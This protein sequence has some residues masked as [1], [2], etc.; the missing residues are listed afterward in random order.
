MRTP[1][2]ATLLLLFTTASQAQ[3]L[4]R[5]GCRFYHGEKPPKA[6]PLTDG[7]L[8]SIQETIAR[9]DTFDIQHYDIRIDVTDYSGKSITASTRVVFTPRM[10]GQDFIRFDL[11][12]LTVDSVTHSSGPLVFTHDGEYLKVDLPSVQ[13]AVSDT[14]TVHYHGDPYREPN[15]GGFYFESQYIYNLG[16]GLTTI[17]PNFGKVWYPCFDSFVERATY[18]YHVKSAG[19]FRAHCQGDFLG[20]VQLG[21][22]TVVRTYDLTEPIPTYGSAIAVADYRD[23]T[24]LHA[25]AYGTYPITLTSKPGV[26]G[27]FV[28]KMADLPGTIDCLE[29]WYGPYT[30]GR[31]G[32]VLTTDGAL[33]IAQNIAYPDFMPGQSLFNNRGLLA[34]EL[35]HQWWGIRVSPYTHNEMWLKEGPAEYSGHLAEEWL[36]GRDAFVD[37]VKDNHLDILRTAHIVDDGFQVLS[38]IPDEHCY[39]THTYYKG[40]SVMHNLRGYL[41]DTLFR[42]GM[43]HAHTALYDTAMTAQDFRDALE[44]GTGYDLDAFFDAWVFQP[45]YSVFVVQDVSVTP[46]GGQWDVELTLRQRL[47]EAWTW[48]EDVPLDLSLL[49]AD[50]QRR[51]FEVMASGEFTT[52]TVTT[53]IEPVMVVLNGHT[54]L[55]QA[56]MDHEFLTWPGD[57]FNSTLPY[58]DFR[59]YDDVLT[60]TTLVRIEHIWAG[61][62]QDLLG[63]GIDE[64]SG[65]HYWRVDGLWP[66]GTEF[67]GRLIYDGAVS[68]DID[69]DLLGGGN[70]ADVLLLYRPDPSQPWEVYPDHTVNLGNPN[71]GNG[72]IDIDVLLPGDYCFGRGNAIASVDDVPGNGGGVLRAYPVPVADRLTVE[73]GASADGVLVI[74]LLASDG[75]LVRRTHAAS[76]GAG[77]QVLDVSELP[78]G[79]YLVRIARRGGEVLGTSRFV[80]AR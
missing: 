6:R 38:P 67:R 16:I 71:D 14:L 18:T 46:N 3:P 36:Y 73:L 42:Q 29:H 48:H 26:L 80:V 74:D 27:Q 58:V 44:A 25:G 24:F 62:D 79:G 2:L 40:A 60:D 72:L 17:P 33:E 76:R 51:E 75:R 70:E 50:R 10:T 37:V 52:V 45:G 55:N 21:G 61:P 68:T 28:S 49:A 43:T 53:D 11:Y 22:D 30:F 8:K 59:L 32:Y 64:I 63:W 39:G 20:E 69:W 66:A 9:S 41:G 15:W 57:N 12:Q 47:R 78:E 35:G 34:H 56:R 19:T 23:S 65:T 31:V 54:R 7:Q 4:K 1:I 77:M 5:L 13:V